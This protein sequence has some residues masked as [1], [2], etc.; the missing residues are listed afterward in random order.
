MPYPRK[1]LTELRTQAAQAIQ[2][3]LPGTNAALRFMV[4]TALAN[5]DAGLAY[6]NY[7]YLA[8]IARQAVPYTAENEYLE[9]WAALKKVYRDAPFQASGVVSFQGTVGKTVLNGTAIN[10]ADGVA[11]TSTADATVA[12][13]GIVLVP[14]KANADPEGLL[15]AFGNTA[16]GVKMSLSAP[17]DGISGTGTVSTAITGGTDL[18]EDEPL[19]ARMLVAYQT[20]PEGGAEGDYKEWV[21]DV[22]GITRAWIKRNGYGAGTVVIY[23]MLDVTEAAHNGFPQG[24]DGVSQYETRDTAATGDQ[25]TVAD[26]LWYLQPVTALVYVVSAIAQPQPFTITGLSTAGSVVQASVL[27]AMAN[28]INQQA[29][30]RG[31]TIDLSDIEAAIAAVP[32]TAG[33][34]ITTPTANITTAIG[35][36][37]TLGTVTFA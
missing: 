15:G 10:R 3:E 28:A 11:F 37:L 34:V 2:S 31:A 25:L 27:A 6:A 17:I 26:A 24:T 5:A 36:L 9:A 21:L 23:I 16:V 13:T 20:R 35:Y 4:T 12:A 19:R 7:A 22:P 33:F 30:P 32:G 8:W 18:E 1:T 29:D 14:V